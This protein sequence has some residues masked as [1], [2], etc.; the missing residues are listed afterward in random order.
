MIEAVHPLEGI[1]D[2]ISEVGW[3]VLQ[4]DCVDLLRE[5][6]PEC[7][8]LVITDPSYESNEKHRTRLNAAGERVQYG[9]TTRLQGPWFQ[10]FPD[11]RIPDLMQEL[12]RVLK[13][14]THAYIFSN[15]ESAQRVIIPEAERAGF[16]WWKNLTWI[17]STAAGKLKIG[18][19]YHWRNCTEL[20]VFLEKG[21]RS[22]TEKGWPEVLFGP[23][24]DGPAEKPP[25][26]LSRLVLNSSQENDLVLDVFAGSGSTGD[27]AYRL[28]RRAL[29]FD[30]DAKRAQARME[31]HLRDL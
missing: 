13:P 16:H 8:D 10:T 31:A 19:G 14:N 29:L 7:I 12:Y 3:C 30:L 5:L 20:V 9:T 6:P 27:V 11:L 2:L 28:K 4:G 17:K 18:M 24:G 25:E 23:A 26:V 22:L 21:K 15:Q 1:G